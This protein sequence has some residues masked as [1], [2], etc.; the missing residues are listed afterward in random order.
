MTDAVFISVIIATRNRAALLARTL[1]A[2]A[3]QQWPR[4]RFEIVVAD[5][6]STDETAAVV[7]AAA[8][9]PGFPAVQYLVIAEPGKSR[10]VNAALGRARGDVLA[11]TD[12]DVT[13]EPNWLERLAAAFADGADFVA[14]RIFPVWE[15]PPPGWMSPALHGV[16]AVP[17]NGPDRLDI[18]GA[19]NVM[20]I[21]A[22]MAVARAIV[23]RVGGLRVDLG[24]IEG[25]LRTG[26]DHDF[27]LRMLAAGFRGVYEPTAIV[28]HWVPRERLTRDYFRRWLYQNGR[29]VAQLE[30]HSAVPPPQA[31]GVPQ[32]LWAQGI[33]DVFRASRCVLTGDAAGRFAAA[34][35]LLW[36]AGYIREAWFS[37][38]A[39]QPKPARI[40][41]VSHAG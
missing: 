1:D 18:G 25:S 24:K 22:N 36:I 19:D 6:G 4:A 20:P 23:N 29:D 14:G 33:A 7:R 27:F 3:A 31:L 12:D 39:P 16:L 40:G 11:F 9:R 2:L 26:E 34:T 30:A 38:P 41:R 17:D 32:Y 13:P 15:T 37:R 21:G 35:R 28:H 10:A 5:N 8:A